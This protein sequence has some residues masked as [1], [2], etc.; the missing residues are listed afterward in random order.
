[1]KTTIQITIES[2]EPL[3]ELAEMFQELVTENLPAH[4]YAV[5]AS[6]GKHVIKIAPNLFAETNEPK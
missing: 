1:M 6:R 4:N 3:K 5:V 2:R